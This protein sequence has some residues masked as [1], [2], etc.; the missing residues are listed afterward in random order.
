MGEKNEKKMGL[1]ES[2]HSE[3]VPRYRLVTV[4][5]SC[6]RMPARLKCGCEMPK[7]VTATLYGSYGLL[8]YYHDQRKSP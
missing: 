1:E 8:L 5:V 7:L 2:N 3:N 6:D 4:I